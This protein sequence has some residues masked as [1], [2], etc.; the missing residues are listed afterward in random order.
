MYSFHLMNKLDTH[1]TTHLHHLE[2]KS[3]KA[4]FLEKFVRVEK[5]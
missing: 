1:L 5:F 2:D 3:R 4:T